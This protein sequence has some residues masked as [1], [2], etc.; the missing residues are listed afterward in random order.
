VQSAAVPLKAGLNSATR[1][2]N[3]VERAR[4]I[5]AKL[6]SRTPHL[7]SAPLEIQSEKNEWRFIKLIVG[8]LVGLVLVIVLAYT[9]VH[10][11]HSWQERRLIRRAAAYLSGGDVKAAALSARRAFQMN[12]ANAD[13]AR[14]MAQIA[15]RA[16]DRTAPEWWRKVLDL[17]PHNTEDAWRPRKRHL[18]GSMKQRSGLLGITRLPAGWRR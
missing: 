9:G 5:G 17:Q 2:F 15:D 3:G 13:A 10:V 14:A 16:G 7:S 6:T 4:P 11:F 18:T 12:P 1:V 8:G